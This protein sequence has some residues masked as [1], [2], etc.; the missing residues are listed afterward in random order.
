MAYGR[1]QK[2]VLSWFA[3]VFLP[4][5]SNLFKNKPVVEFT[6][7]EKVFWKFVCVCFAICHPF[8]IE[9][10]MCFTPLIIIKQLWIIALTS[11]VS[12]SKRGSFQSGPE[13]F[14]TE[15]DRGSYRFAWRLTWQ[16]KFQSSGDGLWHAPSVPWMSSESY[17]HHVW[18]GSRRRGRILHSFWSIRHTG[19]RSTPLCRNGAVL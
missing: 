14:Q 4:V 6:F 7:V 8:C 1:G 5:E 15:R 9:V 12:F 17:S 13:Q 10:S 2:D 19:R 3:N 16:Q 18:S 11:F